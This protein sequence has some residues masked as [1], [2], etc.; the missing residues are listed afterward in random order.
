MGISLVSGK[1]KL[2]QVAAKLII[3]FWSEFVNLH[4][5]DKIK[6]PEPKIVHINVRILA[7]RFAQLKQRILLLVIIY[8]TCRIT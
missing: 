2:C 7:Q 6:Q 3:V 1:K 5:M 4:P 8:R